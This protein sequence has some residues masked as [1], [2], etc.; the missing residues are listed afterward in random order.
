MTSLVRDKGDVQGSCHLE[1]GMA[2]KKAAPVKV[3]SEQIVASL[4]AD[5]EAVW[6]WYKSKHKNESVYA[7]FLETSDTGGT[8]FASIASEESLTN[9]ATE[10][11]DSYD[12]SIEKAKDALRWAG[13]EDC[14]LQVDEKY[15]KA[16]NKLLEQGFD[17]G[18]LD[19]FDG[20]T[21]E[22]AIEALNLFTSS[23]RFVDESD[24]EKIVVGICY[25]GGDNSDKQL[26]DWAKK[27]NSKKVVDRLKKELKKR[28]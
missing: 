4:V 27:L 22:Y 21:Q 15:F 5:I 11:L 16:S 12:G 25:I 14:F 18:L 2:K 9:F 20:K 7:F 17:C 13:T 28:S 8:V 26:L 19:Y 24:R 10:C 6:K 23:G 3:T 1:I